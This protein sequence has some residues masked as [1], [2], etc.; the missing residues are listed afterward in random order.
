[1]RVSLGNQVNPKTSLH[2]SLNPHIASKSNIM[3]DVTNF[4]DHH[5]KPQ[6][7][8]YSN[9]C[10]ENQQTSSDPIETSSYQNIRS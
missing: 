1:M 9:T 6:T 2:N 3:S 5:S 8:T 10:Y 7:Q 4:P